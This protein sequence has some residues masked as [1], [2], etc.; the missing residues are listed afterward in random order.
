MPLKYTLSNLRGKYMSQK[1]KTFLC[2]G[3]KTLPQTNPKIKPTYLS[4]TIRG[5]T[6]SSIHKCFMFLA[7]CYRFFFHTLVFFLI[8]DYK[9]LKIKTV[10]PFSGFEPPKLF[11]K[12]LKIKNFSL[13]WCRKYR[14]I[15]T[16]VKSNK[17]RCFEY[18]VQQFL[19]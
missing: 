1:S 9:L 16:S 13:H 19:N 7:C 2:T 11:P 5:S 3:V 17:N 4:I 12:H 6:I 10:F 8:F 15:F 14:Q 18:V